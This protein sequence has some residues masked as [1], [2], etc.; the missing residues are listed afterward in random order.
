MYEDEF[1]QDFARSIF[2]G[3]TP[4]R[5]PNERP[6]TFSVKVIK[7]PAPDSYMLPG[8]TLLLTTGLFSTLDSE[9]EL[10]A[11]VASEIGHFVLDHALQ[12]VMKAETRARRSEFWGA[13]AAAAVEATEIYLIENHK[14]YV[15]GLTTL[16]ATVVAVMV[17]EKI[18]RRMGMVYTPKQQEKADRLAEDFLRYENIPQGALHSALS[19]IKDYYVVNR[20]YLALSR[21][22]NFE[23]LDKRISRATPPEKELYSR[24]FSKFMSGVTTFNAIIQVNSEKFAEA[25]RLANKNIEQ[26][27]ATWEDYLVLAQATMGLYN[28][29]ESNMRTLELLEKTKQMCEVPVMSAVKQEAL[30][31]LRMNKQAQATAILRNYLELLDEAKQN[32]ISSNEGDW[33]VGEIN[34]TTKLLDRITLF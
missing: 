14:N 20:D 34:W 30:L 11:L 22:G 6:K 29:D 26:N 5:L 12:N 21:G 7:S 17:N 16:G 25:T 31:M 23:D 1:I 3:M 32:C 33:I 9:E 10:K 18:A 27:F 19:K 28:D 8:G 13:V 4:K 24:N 2:V 15:P